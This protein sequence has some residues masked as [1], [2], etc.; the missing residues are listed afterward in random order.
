MWRHTQPVWDVFQAS[1]SGLRWGRH[2]KDLI[3]TSQILIKKDVFYVTS[4]DISNLSQK[5]C[6]WL[7]AF[8]MSQIHLEKDVCY[9]MQPLWGFSNTILK[10]CL[11]GDALETY[12]K[13]LEKMIFITLRGFSEIPHEKCFPV[14]SV[15]FLKYLKMFL[16]CWNA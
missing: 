6:L 2:L 9:V 15:D 14:I 11:S 10:V 4:S 5:R 12:K 7:N 8:L 1:Q 3:D 13:Y 16:S